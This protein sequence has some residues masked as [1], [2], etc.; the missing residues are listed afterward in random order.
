MIGE[1]FAIAETT[2]SAGASAPYTMID[3][4]AAATGI[5]MVERLFCSQST[6]DTSENLSILMGD[7][8]A[9]GTASAITPEPLMK[10]HGAAGTYQVNTTIEGTY[11]APGIIE[12]GFNVLSGF[13]WTPASDDEVIAISPSGIMGFKLVTSIAIAATFNYGATIRE[14]GS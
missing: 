7:M 8:S 2:A 6:Q 13:L 4:T 12:Q 9:T 3:F 14:I 10:G 11:T 1:M 5:V